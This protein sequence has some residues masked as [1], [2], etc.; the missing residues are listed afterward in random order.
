[1]KFKKRKKVLAGAAIVLGGAGAF[2]GVASAVSKPDL[3]PN[4]PKTQRPSPL[5]TCN[6]PQPHTA[7]TIIGSCI[8]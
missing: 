2:G 6:L 7:V 8:E 1:M 5:V 4:P 3:P